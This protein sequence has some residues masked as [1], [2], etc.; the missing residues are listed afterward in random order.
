MEWLPVWKGRVK[1]ASAIN[2]T[3]AAAAVKLY[4]AFLSKG[5][6]SSDVAIITTYRAQSE[7]I[8][9]AIQKLKGEKPITASLYKE[10]PD[11]KFAPEEPENLLDLRVSE[12]VDS[13]QGREKEVV[14]YSVTSHYE[15]EA[16]LDYRRANVAFSRARSKLVILSSL[17][18]MT[19]T[20]WLKYFKLQ[21]RRVK[22]NASELEPEHSIVR[23][24]M[25]HEFRKTH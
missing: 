25:R 15:H 16:L 1:V 21:A 22:V 9:K 2:P 23:E 19:K 4:R 6:H 13:Y 11:K 12:T 24:I 14:L 8:R 10:E 5:I 17:Q 18:S 3:E 20:P 7:L